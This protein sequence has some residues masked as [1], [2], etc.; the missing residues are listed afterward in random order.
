M[1]VADDLRQRVLGALQAALRLA[2]A[3]L[4]VLH[5]LVA[6]VGDVVAAGGR[7]ALGLVLGGGGG[8]TDQRREQQRRE[9]MA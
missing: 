4:G 3:E 9:Q 8:K 7:Q 1:E 2:E 5:R 6:D